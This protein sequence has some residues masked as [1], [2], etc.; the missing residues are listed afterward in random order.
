MRVDLDR[1]REM[2]PGTPLGQGVRSIQAPM[3][4]PIEGCEGMLVCNPD[5]AAEWG[6]FVNTRSCQTRQRFTIAHELGHFVLHRGEQAGFQCDKDAVHLGLGESAAIEREA[7]EFASHLLMPSDVVCKAIADQPIDLRLLSELAD[8]F[9]VSFEALCIRF[10][11]LTE[12][13]AVLLHW[14]N[15]F[16]KYQWHSSQAQQTGTRIRRTADPQE[17]LDGT[18]AFEHDITQEW[19]GLE[20][21][22]CTWFAK[23][24]PHATVREFKHSYGARDRVLT[25]LLLD[26]D[27]T[28]A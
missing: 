18:V 6:I 20:L 21:P 22:A 25:L 28:A 4:S 3:A 17:P 24:A 15:G 26:S 27:Q 1:V 2:L 19:D 10:I 13:R 9:D 11:K 12:Q 5:D 16:L 8:A 7:D 14:D 23:E